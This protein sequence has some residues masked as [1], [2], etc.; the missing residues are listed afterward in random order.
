MR[1][2]EVGDDEDQRKRN[3]WRLTEAVILIVEIAE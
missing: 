1:R 3:Y 2:E